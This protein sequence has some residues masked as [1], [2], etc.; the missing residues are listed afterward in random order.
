M[1]R[2]T[3]LTF[4]VTLDEHNMPESIE[5]TASDN[6]EAGLQASKT[7]MLGLWD[8]Q[9]KNT[10]TIDLWTKDMQI[11]EMHTHYFQRLLSLTDSYYRATGNP[12]VINEIRKFCEELGEK[13]QVWEERGRR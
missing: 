13:T 3:D 9:E 6:A 5:W 1:G 2:K 7:L 4:H 12:F 8:G 10:M 11:D